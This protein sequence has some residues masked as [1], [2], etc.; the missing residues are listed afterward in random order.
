MLLSLLP[1]HNVLVSFPS[2]VKS[3]EVCMLIYPAAST[4][5]LHTKE[6]APTWHAPEF[7]EFVPETFG[8]PMVRLA[9]FFVVPYTSLALAARM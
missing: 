3:T 4:P 2:F 1:N 5:N 7:P 9:T 8:G 6:P